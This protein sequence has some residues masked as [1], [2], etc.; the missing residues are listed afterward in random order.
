M[1]GKAFHT[2]HHMWTHNII[3]IG[4]TRVLYNANLYLGDISPLVTIHIRCACENTVND[5]KV[6]DGIPVISTNAPTQY[7]KGIKMGSLASRYLLIVK[8]G[9]HKPSHHLNILLT[10]NNRFIVYSIFQSENI[11]SYSQC[12]ETLS[13]G[14]L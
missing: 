5:K 1:K 4:L 8:L 7:L 14:N 9:S 3:I 11:H 6:V 10:Y 13:Q 12:Y 2:F